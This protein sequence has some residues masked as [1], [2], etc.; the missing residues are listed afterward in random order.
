MAG[1]GQAKK[2]AAQAFWQA[3][4]GLA[5]K[6]KG[7][8]RVSQITVLFDLDGTLVD[9]APDLINALNHVL[10][11]AGFPPADPAIIRPHIGLG[12]RQ[13]VAAGLH[14]AGQ[15][16]PE[17]R[18][19]A[20]TT[21]LV[22]HYRD[23]IADESRPYQ[24]I[25]EMLPILQREGMAMGICTNKSEALARRLL[26]TLE[27]DHY[28]G[29]IAGG[30]T[31]PVRKP[32]PGHVLGL[33]DML[34]GSTDQ[35]VMVGDSEIDIMTAQAAGIPMIAVSYGYAME[36]VEA[37]GPDIVLHD[38]LSIDA[39]ICALLDCGKRQVLH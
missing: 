3:S 34:G 19:L 29:A 38:A 16:V 32:D 36:P 1:A 33:L 26:Q 28:F 2:T 30:D 11:Q 22:N 4:G 39:A 15:K 35:A 31:L 13:I 9:T 10:A 37:Y 14:A 7:R 25:A 6:G 12:A 8:D 17:D 18:F 24:G 5:D 21:A 20:M 27:L 23:H